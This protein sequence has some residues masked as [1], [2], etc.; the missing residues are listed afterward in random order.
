VR[1]NTSSGIP[2]VI[3]TSGA[4]AQT[5]SPWRRFGFDAVRLARQS[6]GAWVS[7]DAASQGASLSFYTLF[8]LAP[9]LLIATWLAGAILDKNS[10]HQ[11]IVIQ[12]Q[13]LIGDAGATAVSALLVGS[14]NFGNGVV[15]S[16]VGIVSLLIGAT[17][18]FAELQRALDHVWDTPAAAA[19]NGVWQSV[20]TRVLSF[21]LILG[22]GFLLLVS[23]VVSAGL[24][25]FSSWLGSVIAHWKVLLWIVDTL[26][27]VSI[28]TLLFAMI[29]KFLPRRSIA[30]GDVW[31][32]ALVTA[33]LFTAGKVLIG[34]YLSKS[35]FTSGYGAAGSL[36]VLL[37]WIFY[38]A[39]IFLLGAEFTRAF[40][41]KT[42]SQRH[43]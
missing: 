29:Y 15:R 27:G 14:M 43:I 5:T 41:Y 32:G 17:S 13:A 28:A 18:V 38:S 2:D 25:A 23:L 36:L 42:G 20:R 1:S 37:L 30:W 3:R 4:G 8:S 39:Q 33:V 35:A 21:G 16:L 40:A 7:H 11:G 24:A 31:I 19:A 22:V 26:L 34:F 6:I 10:V 12:M 9:V